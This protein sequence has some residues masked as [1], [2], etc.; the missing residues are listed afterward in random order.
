MSII[1]LNDRFRFR[2]SH[3]RFSIFPVTRHQLVDRQVDRRQTALHRTSYSAHRVNVSSVV[4]AVAV[5]GG[6]RRDVRLP[7]AAPLQR[8]TQ[9]DRRHSRCHFTW[10]TAAAAAGQYLAT[11][12]GWACVRAS[13]RVLLS[14]WQYTVPHAAPPPWRHPP[15]LSI[16]FW[17]RGEWILKFLVRIHPRILI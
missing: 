14:C 7:S 4:A 5:G 6:K 3:I 12:G 2:L 9:V 15:P 13:V 10:A 17:L 11:D 16:T 1:E 8:T